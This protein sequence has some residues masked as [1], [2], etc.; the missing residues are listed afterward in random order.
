MF[1][2]NNVLL[3]ATIAGITELQKRIRAKDWDVAFTIA[4]AAIVGALFGYNNYAGI[5]DVVTG[6]VAGF[7]ASGVVTVVGSF[8]NRSQPSP[9]DVVTKE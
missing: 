5:P 3:V 1:E 8:G 6:I 9:S 2:A 7:G 4:F